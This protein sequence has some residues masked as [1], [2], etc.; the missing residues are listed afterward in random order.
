MDHFL[1]FLNEKLRNFPMHVE[2]GYNK[3]ADWCIY[4]YKQGCTDRYPNSKKSGNDA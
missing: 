2:I 3:T 4:I 1:R